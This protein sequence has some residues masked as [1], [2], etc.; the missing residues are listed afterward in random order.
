MSFAQ[1][2]NYPGPSMAYLCSS[3]PVVFLYVVCHCLWL[4]I[5]VMRVVWVVR[6]ANILHLVDTATF[7]TSFVRA[8]TRNLIEIV[9]SHPSGPGYLA[10]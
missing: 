6:W 8:V 4:R 10:E 7:V 5:A 9:S 3:V 1:C 2:K